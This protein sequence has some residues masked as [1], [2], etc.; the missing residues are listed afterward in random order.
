MK[1]FFINSK[2]SVLYS[3]TFM[4]TAICLGLVFL[5]TFGFNTS[6]EY[7]KMYEIT[8]FSFDNQKIESYINT[9]EDILDTY[10]YS[11]KEVVIEEHSDSDAV[12]IRYKSES[13]NNA[14]KIQ[15]DIV[16]ALEIN[17]NL[18][19][20]ERLGV[21]SAKTDS[22][23]LLI[24]LGVMA[25][26]S[27]VYIW[28]RFSW[29]EGVVILSTLGLTTILPLAIMLFTRIELSL[30]SLGVVVML[31]IL[32]SVLEMAI[33]SK[34]DAIARLQDRPKTFKANY[35]EYISSISKRAIIPATLGL[36]V[37]ICFLFTFI[38]SLAHVG[39]TG[40]VGLVISCVVVVVFAPNLQI[41]LNKEEKNKTNEL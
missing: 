24:A 2:K 19:Q 35:L 30:V 40:L 41:L 29:K 1:A 20:V 5:L 6:A 39:L 7:G 8:I 14:I 31:S 23:K 4:A 16:K 10:G 37:F 12:V 32:S 28:L 27:F 22:I 25:V 18:V 38:R 3:L 34:M 13:Q 26:I 15:A 36:L 17:K 21:S 9:T 33:I 11:A